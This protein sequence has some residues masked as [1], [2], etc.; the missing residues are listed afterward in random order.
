MREEVLMKVSTTEIRDM[1]AVAFMCYLD[2]V[3]GRRLSVDE[4]RALTK[5]VD[6]HDFEETLEVVRG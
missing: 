2:E 4:C 6:A 5:W 1:M 3:E